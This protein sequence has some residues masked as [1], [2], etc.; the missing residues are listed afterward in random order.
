VPNR[1]PHNVIAILFSILFLAI[2]CKTKKE[3]VVAP[4]V[5][6]IDTK[7]PAYLLEKMY[8]S[9]T[10]FETL[11]AKFSAELYTGGNN[12]SFKTSIRIKQDSAIWMSISPALGIE[13]ARVLIT[14]DSVFFMN[15]I[16]GTYFAGDFSYF[17]NLLNTEVDYNLLESLLVGNPIDKFSPEDFIVFQEKNQLVLST[18]KKRVIKKTLQKQEKAERL[19]RKEK[20]EKAE[21]VEAKEINII[22]KSAQGDTSIFVQNIWLNADSYKIE[23]YRY[24]DINPD[25]LLHIFYSNFIVINGNYIPQDLKIILSGGQAARLNI[26]YSKITLNGEVSFPYTVPEK[27]EP[28]K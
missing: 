10:K 18:H 28:I 20:P 13:V 26:S 4:T 27:Y 17:S 11:N 25:K 16:N 1:I 5:K 8:Q 22:A 19:E 12:T 21:K 24:R 6:E 7:S 23:E 3:I 14:K 9:E 15:R 2:A